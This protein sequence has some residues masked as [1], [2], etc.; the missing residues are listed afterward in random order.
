MTA[1]EV[2]A[3][4]VRGVFARQFTLTETQRI[5]SAIARFL[6]EKGWVNGV[7]VGY[8]TRFMAE[9]FAERMVS[10]LAGF[11]PV[12][13]CLEPVTAPQIAFAVK[14]WNLSAGILVTASHNP[15]DYQGLKMFTPEGAPVSPEEWKAVLSEEESGMNLPSSAI[16]PIESLS[17]AEEYL[18]NLLGQV[19][20][21]GR[22]GRA[23]RPLKVVFDPLYGSGQAVG[24]KALQSMGVETSLLHNYRDVLFGGLTPDP[25]EGNLKELSGAVT[26]EEADL[27][28][29]LDGDGDRFG[30]VD[31][32]GAFIPQNWI[33]GLLA[34]HLYSQ[35]RLQG[36]LVRTIA[37]THFL[38]RLAA[39]FHQE[40]VETPVG[41]HYLIQAM[42]S[43]NALMGGE[44]NG[45]FGLRGYLASSDG[46][47]AHLLLIELLLRESRP[48]SEIL[49]EVHHTFGKLY[50]KRVD[51]HLASEEQGKLMA[52]LREEPVLELLGN[53]LTEARDLQGV[54]F[55]FEGERWFLVRPSTTEPLLR[56]YMETPQQEELPLMEQKIL[57]Y[58]GL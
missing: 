37:T 28:V 27:G 13:R 42:R 7:L 22:G 55:V 20:E 17:P 23:E 11:L 53:P 3:E 24:Q 54:K 44:E 51:V 8:D 46:L 14:R 19:E 57:T 32:K 48:L 5:T 45:G 40:C 36:P 9:D 41:F 2:T 56:I 25:T 1:L 6:L 31:E 16:F 26:S 38:N 50:S 49:K 4:G 43:K 30:V 34:Y 39:A 33:L 12:F 35:R 47:L 18:K 15:A 21:P 58:L 29:A 10:I 52:R